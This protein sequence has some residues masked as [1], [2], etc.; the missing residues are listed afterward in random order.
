MKTT[1][2]FV[3]ALT[4]GALSSVALANTT[5]P[6]KELSES[7]KQLLDTCGLVTYGLMAIADMRQGNVS[8]ADAEKNLN[9]MITDMVA[10]SEDKT[11]ANNLGDFWKGNLDGLYQVPVYEK[12]EEKMEF[13]NYVFNASMHTC[14]SELAPQASDSKAK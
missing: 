8:K 3:A 7:E 14:V 13:L 12:D 10:Q 11:G 2:K 5:T 1:A 4:L 9:T 6:A